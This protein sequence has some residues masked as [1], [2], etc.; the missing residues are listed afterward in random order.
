MERLKFFW[1]GEIAGAGGG[2]E[3]RRVW[4]YRVLGLEQTTAP[5]SKYTTNI[6]S[7]GKKRK[8]F[9]TVVSKKRQRRGG[10]GETRKEY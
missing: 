5:E 3:K 1:K 10:E 8:G 7:T 9:P 2:R 4:E 6:N